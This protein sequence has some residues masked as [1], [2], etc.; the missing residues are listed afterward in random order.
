MKRRWKRWNNPS[1]VDSCTAKNEVRLR[2]WLFIVGRE[3]AS[4]RPVVGVPTWWNDVLQSARG[5]LRLFA[6]AGALHLGVC[7]GSPLHR[8]RRPRGS[9]LRARREHAARGLHHR[10]L[11][12]SPPPRA[13]ARCSH[14]SESTSR[15]AA[16]GLLFLCSFGIIRARGS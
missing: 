13:P 9:Y 4:G 7:G 5:L 12:A 8:G 3:P 11:A 1:C 2:A 10:K 6:S 15:A 14:T 16:G